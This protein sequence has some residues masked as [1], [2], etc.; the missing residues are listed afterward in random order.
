LGL[1][2]ADFGFYSVEKPKSLMEA[3]QMKCK[4]CSKNIPDFFGQ[5]CT[6][7]DKLFGESQIEIAM[8]AGAGE[9]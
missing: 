8:E 1:L 6:L 2:L 5:Y 3:M 7:C 9:K 4:L